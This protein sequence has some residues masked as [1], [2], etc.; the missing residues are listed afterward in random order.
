MG[1]SKLQALTENWTFAAIYE[2]DR[3]PANCFIKTLDYKKTMRCHGNS[4]AR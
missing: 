4:N 1:R 2:Y 3:K